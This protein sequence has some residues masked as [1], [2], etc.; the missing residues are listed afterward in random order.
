MSKAEAQRKIID[1][2]CRF[3]NHRARYKRL[4]EMLLA[5]I[6]FTDEQ[7]FEIIE[8]A[9]KADFDFIEGV[10]IELRRLSK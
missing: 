1:D 5:H 8:Q 10:L 4:C 6:G 3:L 9:K 7:S 2:S